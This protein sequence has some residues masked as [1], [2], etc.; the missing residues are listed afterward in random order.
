M[1][2][3]SYAIKRSMQ[4]YIEPEKFYSIYRQEL[5]YQL[6]LRQSMSDYISESVKDQNVLNVLHTDLTTRYNNNGV[7]SERIGG[8]VGGG[9]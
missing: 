5:L 4:K 9:Y 6:K 1:I 3:V 2:E 7:N 8:S